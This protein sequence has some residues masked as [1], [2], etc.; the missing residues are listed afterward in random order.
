[1][2][3]YIEADPKGSIYD[4]ERPVIPPVDDK[5]VTELHAG[6]LLFEDIWPSGGDY[7]MNDVII[8]YSRAVT[9]TKTT[10]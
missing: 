6:T 4:P 10:S 8:E 1:M 2:L 5:P 9:F 3:F 7:D